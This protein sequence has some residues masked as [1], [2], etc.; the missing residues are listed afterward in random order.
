MGKQ[1][2]NFNFIETS[3]KDVYVIEPKKYGDNREYQ[4]VVDTHLDTWG[5]FVEPSI[6]GVIFCSFCTKNIDNLSL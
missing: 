1:V 3:I 5:D 2:G 4:I 6:D